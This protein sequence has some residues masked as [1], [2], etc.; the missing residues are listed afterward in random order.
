MNT[1]KTDYINDI[2]KENNNIINLMGQRYILMTN[3]IYNEINNTGNIN[4]I[5][6]KILFEDPTITTNNRYIQ[7]SEY[8]DPPLN[9]FGC[10]HSSGGFIVDC[11]LCSI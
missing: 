10:N 2:I 7:L 1:N 6:A 4:N 9:T 5:F 8:F 11:S 3:N